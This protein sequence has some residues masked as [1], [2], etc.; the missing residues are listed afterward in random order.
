M[1]SFCAFSAK[2]QWLSP[3]PRG[4]L[5]TFSQ[6]SLF[7][8][9]SILILN[10][11]IMEC[12]VQNPYRIR[13]YKSMEIITLL[14][15]LYCCTWY[16]LVYVFVYNWIKRREF[17]IDLNI[18]YNSSNEWVFIDNRYYLGPN[19]NNI[20]FAIIFRKI[21]NRSVRCSWSFWKDGCIMLN[22]IFI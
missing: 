6:Y 12:K 1:G 21:P 14:F 2:A 17:Y 9:L 18:C 20:K 13:I 5:S 22:I 4:S 7:S 16:K 19:L 10:I 15:W 11:Y 8:Y 3:L